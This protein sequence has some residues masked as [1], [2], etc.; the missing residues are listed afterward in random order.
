MKFLLKLIMAMASLV[1]IAL[2]I[3]L[4]VNKSYTVERTYPVESNPTLAFAFFSNIEN[5]VMYTTS[6]EENSDTEVWTEGYPNEEGQKVCWKSK[7]KKIGTG[8]LELI[9]IEPKKQIDFKLRITEPEKIEADVIL[10]ITAKG[11]QKTDVHIKVL[12]EIPYPW[13]LSL[14]FVDLS[15]EIG[16]VLDE[17]LNEVIPHIE[18]SV[19]HSQLNAR[20]SAFFQLFLF[21]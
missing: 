4:F 13:N 9:A 1:G 12:G 15:E 7:D 6:L 10:A 8:E 21:Q 19:N 2:I 14:L 20:R 3:A 17:N 16:K 5:L 18:K 11:E